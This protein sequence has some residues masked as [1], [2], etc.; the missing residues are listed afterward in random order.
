MPLFIICTYICTSQE[1]SGKVDTANFQAGWGN[2]NYSVP[3][4]PSF[5]IL[6]VSPDNIMK[7]TSTR[8]IAVS[9][10]NYYVNNGATIPKNISVEISPGLFSP[11]VNLNEYRQGRIW[12]TSSYS[13]GT[14]ANGDGSYDIALG[15]KLKLRDDADLRTNEKLEQF[16]LNKGPIYTDAYEN[17][18]TEV[19]KVLGLQIWE[20]AT[21]LSDMTNARYKEVKNKIDSVMAANKEGINIQEISK[22]R[23]GIKDSLWNAQVWDLGLAVL[24]ASKDSL[25]KDLTIKP[26]IIGVWTTYGY[27]LTPKSQILVGENVQGVDTGKTK[28][29][30]WNSNTGVRI[31]YGKNDTKGFFTGELSV[32]QS[33]LP[34]HKLALG[35]ETTFSDGL[36]I[37]FSLGLQ[38]TG[39]QDAIFTPGINI[40]YATGERNSK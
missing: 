17:A 5:K 9:V 8:D 33:A 16:I 35:L 1:S 4:S 13:I 28:T 24:F 22:F 30:V 12:Y 10:G 25:V 38:K 37:D 18:H 3:E 6:G 11:K 39:S 31:Y 36:W 29:V 40:S 20:I 19:S 32:K 34:V 15:A 14:K 27:P 21:I 23:N 26:N 2:L 7:P